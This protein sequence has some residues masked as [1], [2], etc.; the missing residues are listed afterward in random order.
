MA[1]QRSESTKGAAKV[2]TVVTLVSVLSGLLTIVV[3]GRTIW[4]WVGWHT[5]SYTPAV[6]QVQPPQLK[7]PGGEKKIET[8][9]A[10]PVG[11]D[12]PRPVPG[13]RV[14]P[15]QYENVKVSRRLGHQQAALLVWNEAGEESLLDLESL[16]AEMLAKAGVTPVRGFFTQAFVSSGRAKRL[17]AGDWTSASDLELMRHVDYVLG[18]VGNIAY[19][20]SQEFPGLITA[21]VTLEVKCVDATKLTLCGGRTFEADGAGYTKTEAIA[22][23]I[24]HL[25][26]E[27]ES[28]TK[29]VWG[30]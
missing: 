12:S 15:E 10:K 6:S 23:A 25:R 2:S 11:E 17:L 19:G 9:I 20:S 8:T 28:F 4:D 16:M 7:V 13:V 27:M 22:T 24:D 30:Q 26:P 21:N 14:R 1:D 5:S 3:Y 18:A 29:G